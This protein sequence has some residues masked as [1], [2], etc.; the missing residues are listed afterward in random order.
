MDVIKKF[1]KE[2]KRMCNSFEGCEECPADNDKDGYG[3]CVFSIM[4]EYPIEKQIEIV[5]KWSKEH[6]Q[7]TRQTNFLERWPNARLDSHGVLV[8]QPCD[9]GYDDYT[10]CA[11]TDCYR[12]R[13]QFWNEPVK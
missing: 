5:E 8:I 4:S 12:C 10:D 6:P 2:R 9:L 1:L 13:E 11:S 7:K 3:G